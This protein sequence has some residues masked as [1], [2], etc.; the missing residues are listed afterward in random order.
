MKLRELRE[1]I[2]DYSAE[3]LRF[4][5]AEL[6]RC[7]PSSIRVQRGVDDLLRD[8]KSAQPNELPS[9]AQPIEL[10]DA[11]QQ[12]LEQAR[13]GHYQQPNAVVP[14]R[15]RRSWRFQVNRWFKALSGLSEESKQRRLQKSLLE[16]L[17]VL[18]CEGLDI[19]YFSENTPF[20]SCHIPQPDFWKQLL[21]LKWETE[22]H[23]DFVQNSFDLLHRCG[24]SPD[25]GVAP[26]LQHWLDSLST[27]AL[28]ELALEIAGDYFKSKAL[29]WSPTQDDFW[30]RTSPKKVRNHNHIVQAAFE[31]QLD[32]FQP[33]EAIDL[34]L[35][36]YLHPSKISTYNKL[37]QLLFNRRRKDEVEQLLQEAA[38]QF[39]IL[40][41][42]LQSL[43]ET[44]QQNGQLPDIWPLKNRD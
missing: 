18:L 1:Q 43:S 26:L 42:A 38:Q 16:A 28:R 6:Y 27:P 33:Q 9:N 39:D 5:I 32:L 14:E 10:S 15:E 8:P 44:L 13:A 30:N 12:F 31:L 40:P 21:L 17:Y 34:F 23:K 3:D 24:V 29:E 41:P 20:R 22:A 36:H 2:E 35:K 11:I 4:L 25:T 19:Y 37:I 7:L